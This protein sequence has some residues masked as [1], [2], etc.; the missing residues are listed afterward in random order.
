MESLY[1]LFQTLTALQS[2]FCTALVNVTSGEIER[3]DQHGETVH[4]NVDFDEVLEVEKAVMECP[5]VLE[6]IASLN[7]PSHLEVIP[8]PWVFGSDGVGCN[9]RLFQVYMFIR[10]T[11]KLDSNHY[12]RPL[13]FSP[14]FNPNTMKLESIERISTTSSHEA[15]KQGTYE[16]PPKNEYVPD[17]IPLRTDLKPLQVVQPD[18][19]SFDISHDKVLTWQKW[20]MRVGFNYREGMVLRDVCYDGKPLFYRVS[21]SDMCIPYADPRSPYHRKMAFDLGDV[22]AGIVCNDLKLGC[23]CLGSIAYLDG[24]VCDRDGNPVVKKNAVCIHEQDNGIGW[25][26]SNYRTNSE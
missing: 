13:S 4:G 25:K 14:V 19:P 12:A 2:E 10:E 1:P 23:D 9:K 3:S 15:H 21:L 17:D 24:L 18:G 7:L 16:E 20:Y 11:G 22:G 26:H 8:E 6:E 5:E